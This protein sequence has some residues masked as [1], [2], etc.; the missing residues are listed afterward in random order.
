MT[1]PTVSLKRW[2]PP[3]ADEQTAP[4]WHALLRIRTP[5][6]QQEAFLTSAAKR[7]VIRA[8]RRGGKTVGVAILA[9]RA[10]KD[11]RRV[12]Y[13]T[14]TQEQVDR[15]WTE[16]KN[17][18]AAAID[19]GYLAK[20]ET[21]HLIEVP[22][23][24]ARIRAKTAWDADTLRGDY[25][26]LL[27]LDEFQLMHEDTWALVGAPMLLDNDGD[28]VFIYTPPSRRSLERSRARDP[29][30]AAKLYKRADADTSGR[31]ETF[32]F[33]S[34]ANPF[35][36]EA[37]LE[38]ITGDMT[39][40]AYRQEILASDE[41]DVPGALWK[42]QTIDALR[43]TGP[44]PEL[45]RIVTALDPSNTS[46]GDEAGVV[47]AGVGLCRCKGTPELHGFV[48]A[49]DSIQGSPEQWASSGVSAYQRHDADALVAEDNNGGEMVAVVIGTI[50]GAPQVK[51][52]HASRG[53]QTRAEPVSICYEQGKVHHVGIFAALEDEM[54]TWVSGMESPNRMDALVWALTE[55]LLNGTGEAF[56]FSYLRK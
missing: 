29:R 44:L 18:C 21:R 14:P 37:A 54:V 47:T 34:H 13:A 30:H 32:H 40:L 53:K 8:G 43:W 16:C 9:L 38:E 4:A 50:P 36:S 22:Q 56:M 45:T 15:F 33:A 41:E 48:L 52:I 23:S 20:N 26:D 11:G 1:R 25:A 51:R 35:I 19:A 31:W 10:L 17:A 7:K 39:D 6:P 27:I 5:G 28:A 42:R 46:T 55:V 2:S 3:K 24:E 12:L 49:D